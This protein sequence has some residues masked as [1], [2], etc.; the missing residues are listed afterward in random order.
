MEKL[1][2]F[3]KYS[4]YLSFILPLIFTSRTMY[5]W[6]FGKTVLFQAFIE[7]LLILAAIYF[8]EKGRYQ[9]AIRL[10]KL[11]WAV[12]VFFGTLVVSAIFG[13]N[14]ERSFWGNQARA[15]GI[16]SLLHFTA[17][18]GL[19]RIFWREKRD[20]MKAGGSILAVSII[21]AL[22]GFFG[23]SFGF[24]QNAVSS[25]GRDSGLIG[26]PIFYASY[27]FLP[28]FLG[29]AAFF[30]FKNDLNM[31]K[32][33]YFAFI[34]GVLSVAGMIA[35][36]TRGAFIGI[37][38]GIIVS[39]IW[40]GLS[41]GD[42]KTKRIIAIGGLITLI[43]GGLLFSFNQKSDFLRQNAPQIS[44][45]LNISFDQTTAQTRLMAWQIAVR[46]WQDRPFFGWGPENYQDSFDKYYNPEFLQYSFAETVWDKPHNYHLEIL[47]NAGAVGFV[48]Y[49]WLIGCLFYGLARIVKNREKCSCKLFYIVL[50]GGAVGYLAQNSFAF[51]T[52]NSLMLWMVLLGFVS[53][54]TERLR[55]EALSDLPKIN[56]SILFK[57][58]QKA[59]FIALMLFILISPYFLY[60]NYRFFK[61]SVMMGDARDTA[62]IL[63]KYMWMKTAPLAFDHPVPFSWEWAIFATRDLVSFE[64]AGLLDKEML[65]LVK[66]DIIEIL[67]QEAQ[68]NP[69]SYLYRFWL[70]QFYGLL[71]G[72]IDN[73]YYEQSNV[74]L[75][76][77]WERSPDRQQIPLLLA[78]N[79]L[80]QGESEK[81]IEILRE[82]IQKN[83]KLQ[84][85]HWFLGLALI[86]A[87]QADEGVAELEKGREF[88]MG[89]KQNAL[90]L[91]DIYA[92]RADYPKL[93]GVYADLV[94]QYPD[95]ASLYANMAAV[96]AE[97]DDKENMMINL[98]K[99]VELDPSL[100]TEAEAFLNN[101]E[102]KV[103]N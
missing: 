99:A 97:I 13:V 58:T 98:N 17:F 47:A 56:A 77:A 85:P 73:K 31:Q 100:A 75:K 10:N 39:A 8:V 103:A 54:R 15:Q 70:S 72:Y 53:W 4:L 3:I 76:E 60:Q 18:Y 78:K 11:D 34:A 102:L 24:L 25:G 26:N 86:N 61:A 5:P 30:W 38:I 46:A 48:A 29:F 83:D 2:K 23:A 9:P 42:Q 37:V 62:D 51:E 88:G 69:Q 67:S 84:E 63:S 93:L 90:Y 92:G 22:V 36:G 43:L 87:G 71:G 74:I 27:L 19:T 79:Y 20:W 95:D 52:S 32:W 21:S 57:T 80:I 66:G 82:L 91:A 33:R 7:I 1:S 55:M 28:A 35:S 94:K 41:I 14:F 65:N 40:T 49:A 16:F 44:Q 59:L 45:I 89:F 50:A 6:H 101:Y 12:M 96:Y 68:N 64:S 81:G